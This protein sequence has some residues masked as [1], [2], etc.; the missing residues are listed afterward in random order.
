VCRLAHQRRSHPFIVYPSSGIHPRRRDSV[1]ISWIPCYDLF[2]VIHV[3]FIFHDLN[4][5]DM[6]CHYPRLCHCPYLVHIFSLVT[7]SFRLFGFVIHGMLRISQ[8]DPAIAA[9]AHTH[10]P[11]SFFAFGHSAFNWFLAS[12]L[13]SSRCAAARALLQVLART[14]SSIRFFNI[15]IPLFALLFP[16]TKISDAAF[17]RRTIISILCI[18]CILPK[19]VKMLKDGPAEMLV[20]ETF[21]LS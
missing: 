1:L 13:Y 14:P 3:S 2:F 21:P 6:H 5:T 15:T 19:I 9:A 18:L 4:F 10:S 7:F 12:S 8:L 11:Y 17:Q 16:S 20:E